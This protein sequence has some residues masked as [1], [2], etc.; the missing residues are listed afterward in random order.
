MIANTFV[1]VSCNKGE[2]QVKTQ[3]SSVRKL[4]QLIDIEKLYYEYEASKAIPDNGNI[5][6]TII[7]HLRKEFITQSK[8]LKKRNP[9]LVI[10]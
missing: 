4:D 10:C 1:D 6:P 2:N 7:D 9:R 5:N 8:Q 3:R